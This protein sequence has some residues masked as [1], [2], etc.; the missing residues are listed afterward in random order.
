MRASNFLIASNATGACNQP[1]HLINCSRTN[2]CR[3]KT[4]RFIRLMI[5]RFFNKYV[6]RR[7]LEI[8]FIHIWQ[9]LMKNHV[10]NK[11]SILYLCVLIFTLFG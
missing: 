4:L 11:N 5:A 1:T 8:I 6:F 9:K 7:T 2:D 3:R 10:K